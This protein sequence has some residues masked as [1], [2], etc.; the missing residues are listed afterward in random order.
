MRVYVVFVVSCLCVCKPLSRS[1]VLS[2][3]VCIVAV[4]VLSH[5]ASRSSVRERTLSRYF[6]TPFRLAALQIALRAAFR[7][8]ELAFHSDL[9]HSTVESRLIHYCLKRLNRKKR[10]KDLNLTDRKSVEN[11]RKSRFLQ[12][13]SE[14][15]ESRSGSFVEKREKSDCLFSSAKAGLLIC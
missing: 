7:N 6:R 5:T 8:A 2:P 3:P 11:D 12:K 4:F 14:G 9:L 10:R 13:L 15:S 1:L